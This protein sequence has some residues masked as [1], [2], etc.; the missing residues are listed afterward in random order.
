MDGS[1][2]DQLARALA[3]VRTRRTALAAAGGGLAAPALARLD[4]SG[5]HKKRKK[6]AKKC[7][8]GCCTSKFGRCIKPAQQNTSQCGTGGGICQNS[9][10]CSATLPCPAGQCCNGAGQCG[11]CK[12]FVTST[13]G[14]GNIGGLAGADAECQRLANAANLPGTYM[15]W[16]SDATASPASR[17]TKATVPYTLP[18][19]EVVANSW[20]DLTSGSTIRHVIDQFESGAAV[21]GTN[22]GAFR[23]WTNT[24]QN[25]SAGG[26]DPNGFCQNW[27]TDSAAPT[28]NMGEIRSTT[29]WTFGGFQQCPVESRLYCFQQR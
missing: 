1:Q 19:G 16:L 8:D 3:T 6:C 27:T 2:F 18:G 24:K 12:V 21:S 5:K 29:G 9:C 13:K 7:R 26:T 4:V 22:Q 10:P 28:G 17:F 25:G 15:A 20:A 14:T 11:E 23:A